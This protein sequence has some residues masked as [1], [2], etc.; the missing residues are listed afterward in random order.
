MQPAQIPMQP[1]Q[2]MMQPQQQRPMMQPQQQPPMQQAM[3]G[4]RIPGQPI[5]P[6]APQVVM[7]KP[8]QTIQ[9]PATN[10]MQHPGNPGVSLMDQKYG[11]MPAPTTNSLPRS[12]A[13]IEFTMIEKITTG[14]TCLFSSCFFCF[15]FVQI[16]D[17]ERAVLLRHG[18]RAHDKTLTGGLHYMLPSIDS[19][20]KIDIREDIID[21]P[22][23]SVVTREGTQLLV[24]AVVY[25][26]V[27]DANKALLE[28]A[29]VQHSIGLIAQTKLREV[30]A[31]HTYQQ[32]QLER[33]ALATRLKAILDQASEPWGVDI[34]R[35]EL[36]DLKLPAAT[37]SAMNA[38][39][40]SKRRAIADLVLANSRAAIQLID[41][42]GRA[43]AQFINAQAAAEVKLVH[44]R[45]AAQAKRIEAEG[46]R[47][48]AQA[49]KNAAAILAQ[50]PMALKLRYLQTL[51]SVGNSDST[52][53]MIPFN[54]DTAS[55]A[56]KLLGR[57]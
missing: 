53:Y 49:T 45:G 47:K 24:N 7:G 11:D 28:I 10:M 31:L 5:S 9:P 21:I 39:Q 4:K 57:N 13:P 26:R 55:V 22:Q 44:S 46:E 37:Q 8:L 35:V 40:E 51:N 1:A 19:L 52:T 38:E 25:Y 32:I 43:Q 30:L 56:S 42:E 27:F 16:N 29:N 34:T 3:I 20:L 15:N 23:Q 54:Q 48:A 50:T 17:F 6:T 33:L 18:K 14:A 2:I 36:T 41:A 12:D